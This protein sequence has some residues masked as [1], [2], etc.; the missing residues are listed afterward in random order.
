MYE[1]EL[2]SRR[3][4][5]G[6]A[7][8]YDRANRL[9]AFLRGT[10]AR[11]ERLKAIARLRLTPG[12]RVLEVSCGTG[13]N[14]LLMQETLGG[15]GSLTGLDISRGM[16][17]KCRDKVGARNFGVRLIE[18]E[19]AHLPFDEGAFD[20]VF[21]HGGL[22][23]FGDTAGALAEM[24]R[25]AKDGARIVVCDVG[26]PTDHRLPLMSRLLLRTQPVYR[27]PPPIDLLPPGMQDVRLDWFGGGGWYL[28]E[29]TNALSGD[30]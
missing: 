13:T 22:A 18:A 30:R 7:R 14:L 23:E 2:R 25:V 28:L 16:L 21:H 9:A 11:R 17:L 27:K 8:W 24:S 12:D 4:Y 6:R 15:A 19:A 10:S 20:A 3:Y 5:E 29:Y 26:V 1:D